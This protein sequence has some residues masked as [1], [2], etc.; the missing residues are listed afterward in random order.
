MDVYIARQPIFNRNMKVYGYELLY[1]QSINNYFE[2]AD[3][4]KA[5]TALI[6]N[7]FMVFGFQELTEQTRGFINF[8]QNLLLNGLAYMLPKDQVV[9]EILERI[10]PSEEIIEACKKLKE[11]GYKL[12]LDDFVLEQYTKEYLPLIEMADIVKVE[13]PAIKGDG[14]QKV[15]DRFCRNKTFLAEKV[16]TREEHRRA[17]DM[18]FKLFQGYYF[19]KPVLENQKDIGALNVNLLRIVNVL[20]IE[21]VD[22]DKIAEAIQ[23]DVGLS[24]KFLKMSNSVYYGSKYRIKNI[25]QGLMFLGSDEIKRWTYLMLLRGVQC[26]DNAELVKNSI[27]RSK[28]L[29]LLAKELHIRNESDYFIAGMFSAVDILMNTSMDKALIGLPLSQEVREALLGQKNR[30]RWYLDT[31]LALEQAKWE[32]L[33]KS[34]DYPQLPAEK[35][36]TLYLEAIKWQRTLTD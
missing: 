33:S 8:S 3:D 34:S 12:A 24:Y 22:Y 18:G 13:F 2:G 35:Y 1:R 21:P 16:E 11:K 25:K 36:M 23:Q 30:L 27:I 17:M 14:I 19:S 29:S 4:D 26:T 31:V 20:N 32:Q 28:M 6:N 7:S 5:T 15:I 10:E 9:I